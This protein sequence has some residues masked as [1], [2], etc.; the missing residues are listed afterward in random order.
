MYRARGFGDLVP[1][2]AVTPVYINPNA[3]PVTCL[4]FLGIDE[5]CIGPL[6]SVEMYL[7]LGVV[8]L[9]MFGGGHGR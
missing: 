6:G 3:T 4:R 2:T 8:A 7:V 1:V 5:G 9:F